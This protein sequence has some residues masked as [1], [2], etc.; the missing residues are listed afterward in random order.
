MNS[1]SFSDNE[2]MSNLVIIEQKLVVFDVDQ[3]TNAT[4]TIHLRRANGA[5]LVAWRFQV[6][7]KQNAQE[8]VFTA[9]IELSTTM[10]NLVRTSN[11]SVD[12][13]TNRSS[14][15][16][17]STSIA[18]ERVKELEGWFILEYHNLQAE[19]TV[20]FIIIEFILSPRSTSSKTNQVNYRL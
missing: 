17:L 7:D 3:N 13:S 1:T 9:W 2:S 6:W 15:L 20:W 14:I 12:E 4:Q 16:D 10:M 5:A 8:A 11:L 18:V 19:R